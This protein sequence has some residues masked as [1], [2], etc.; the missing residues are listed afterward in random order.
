MVNPGSS[1]QVKVCGEKICRC[2]ERFMYEEKRQYFCKDC[3]IRS[4]LPFLLTIFFF[5]SSVDDDF[6]PWSLPSLHSTL[7]QWLNGFSHNKERKKWW[8]PIQSSLLS[9]FHLSSPSPPFILAS[10]LSPPLSQTNTRD[11]TESKLQRLNVIS[12][13]HALYHASLV[14]RAWT[15]SLVSW[16]LDANALHHLIG[17]YCYPA[18]IQPLNMTFTIRLCG[19]ELKLMR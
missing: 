16:V 5:S 17:K 6:Y 14:F 4:K 9:C 8:T 7:S 3:F 12:I 1:V 13:T 18:Q 19:H 2:V 10:S 15:P 11:Q